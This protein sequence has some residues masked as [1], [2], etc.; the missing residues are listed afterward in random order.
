MTCYNALRKYKR[1]NMRYDNLYKL[2]CGRKPD[3]NKLSPEI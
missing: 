1:E 3:P 2:N